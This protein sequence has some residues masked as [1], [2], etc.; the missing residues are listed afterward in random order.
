MKAKIN[1]EIFDDSSLKKC[2]EFGFGMK[3]LETMYKISF[4]SMLS[5]ICVDGANYTLSVE[6]EDNTLN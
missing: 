5:Q 2:E 3:A 1:I 4:E 6:V